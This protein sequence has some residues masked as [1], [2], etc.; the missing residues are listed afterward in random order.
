MSAPTD[1]IAIRVALMVLF[2]TTVHN[3]ISALVP[4]IVPHGVLK[5]LCRRDR[6]MIP[7]KF[8]STLHAVI[9]GTLAAYVIFVQREFHQQDQLY[10]YPKLLDWA[11]PH[12]AG[13]SVYDMGTMYL[14]GGWGPEVWLHHAMTTY[15]PV[16]MMLYRTGAI[17]VVYLMLVEFTAPFQNGVWFYQKIVR[18]ALHPHIPRTSWRSHHDPVYSMLLFLRA[19]SFVVFRAWVSLHLWRT[20]PFLRSHL[21][22]PKRWFGVADQPE[23]FLMPGY[24]LQ[25]WALVMLSGVWMVLTFAAWVR[26]YRKPIGKLH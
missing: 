9:T 22:N 25:Y 14:Q 6:I 15:T 2:Y 1:M 5:E 24:L 26:E 19:I 12:L 17:G 7:E 8:C 23:P 18:P 16:A 3:C 20:L 11:L 10:H 4:W 13:Y 21:T